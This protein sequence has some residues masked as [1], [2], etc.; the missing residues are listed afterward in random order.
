MADQSTQG[1]VVFSDYDILR[2][3]VTTEKSTRMAESDQYFFVVRKEATKRDIKEA[4][5]RVFG[6]KVK[7]VNTCIRKGK[8]KNFRGRS[9]ILSDKKRAM[10]RLEPGESLNLMTGV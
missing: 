6:V 2:Y 5:E 1:R 8:T 3:P 4:V 7:S 9:A 10:V